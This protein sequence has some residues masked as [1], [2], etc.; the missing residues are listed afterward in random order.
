[1][2]DMMV[3]PSGKEQ[4]SKPPFGEAGLVAGSVSPTDSTE[5]QG[6]WDRGGLHAMEDDEKMDKDKK[7]GSEET[8]GAG[9]GAPE[10]ACSCSP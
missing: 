3:A 2:V 9:G 4:K 7:A 6:M 8:G 5:E 10:G 1:M